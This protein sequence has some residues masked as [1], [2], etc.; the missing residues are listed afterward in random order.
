LKSLGQLFLGSLTLGF[1]LFTWA[2]SW[3]VVPGKTQAQERPRKVKKQEKL[4][5][6]KTQALVQAQLDL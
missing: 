6:G 5:T 1:N 3:P 4:G 2:G